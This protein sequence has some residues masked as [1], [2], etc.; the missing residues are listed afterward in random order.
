[1]TKKYQYY[2][3]YGIRV[4]S[5]VQNQRLTCKGWQMEYAGAFGATNTE[6]IQAKLYGI[7]IAYHYLIEG[8]TVSLPD[9]RS[10]Y[11]VGD[12]EEDEDNISI[13]HFQSPGESYFLTLVT[14]I[15]IC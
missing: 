11:E 3:M 10:K 5:T 2:A 9:E 8:K 1:M 6:N 4:C 13:L 7:N 14:L 12:R 15:R